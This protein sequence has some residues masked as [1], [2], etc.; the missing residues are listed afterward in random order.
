MRGPE[1]YSPDAIMTF[2]TIESATEQVLQLTRVGA[3]LDH[4]LDPVL[5]FPA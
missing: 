2:A 3:A 5:W 4:N 1:I